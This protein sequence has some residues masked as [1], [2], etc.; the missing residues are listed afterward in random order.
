M[1]RIILYLAG[2]VFTGYLA[3]IYPKML[4][5]TLFALEALLFFPA[6]LTAFYFSRCVRISLQVPVPVAEKNQPLE[7]DIVLQNKGFFPILNMV[8]RLESSNFYHKGRMGR[9]MHIQTGAK[10]TTCC[11]CVL[12]SECCGQIRVGIRKAAVGDLL[13]I[14]YLPVRVPGEREILAVMPKIEPMELFVDSRNWDIT[15]ESDEYD[16]VRPGDDPAEVL[17]IREYRSGDRMQRI[18][19]KMTAREDALMVKEYSR[20]IYC[21]V[22]LFLDLHTGGGTDEFE[23]ADEYLEKVLAVSCGLL[24]LDYS[25][26]VVWYDAAHSQLCRI[27]IKE[28]ENIYELIERLFR[29]LPYGDGVDTE[30]MYHQEYPGHIYCLFYLLNMNLELWEG[31]NFSCRDEKK[32]L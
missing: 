3:L 12:Q 27:Q 18:H 20:P 13:G 7:V 23:N 10:S 31:G 21:A 1:V 4:L 17:Q 6:L 15:G 9:K 11:K 26:F 16:P 28:Q 5:I 30:E 29:I 24:E 2:M 25:H 19:W 14:F 8:L 22:V 32:L